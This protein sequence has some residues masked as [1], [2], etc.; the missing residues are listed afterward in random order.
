MSPATG[1]FVTLDPDAEKYR[2]VSPY[3]YCAGNPVNLVD[4]DGKVIVRL[5]SA[6]LSAAIDYVGQV[7]FNIIDDGFSLEAFGNVDFVDTAIAF[8]EGFLMHTAPYNDPRLPKFFSECSSPQMPADFHWAP[9]WGTPKT[10]HTPV[11]GML[12]S[13]NPHS[14]TPATAYSLMHDSYFDMSYAQTFMSYAEVCLLKSELI[15]LGLGS[16]SRSDA[17]YYRLVV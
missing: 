8:G 6:V 7:A 16:G 9:W 13:T 12:D 1:R 17:E 11:S 14:G 3:A 15:H 5:A 4:S 10:D 2:S